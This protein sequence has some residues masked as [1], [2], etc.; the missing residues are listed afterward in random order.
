M[1]LFTLHN[2]TTVMVIV[3]Y[4][5]VAAGSSSA[6]RNGGIEIPTSMALASSSHRQYLLAAVVYTAAGLTAAHFMAAGVLYGVRR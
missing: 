1:R 4:I 6:L 3:C 5:L 2:S